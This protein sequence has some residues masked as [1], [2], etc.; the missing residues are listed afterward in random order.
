[1]V[2]AYPRPD[3]ALVPS[4]DGADVVLQ[5]A[6]EFFGVSDRLDVVGHCIDRGQ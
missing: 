5:H 2:D 1:M 3:L 4:N 6:R